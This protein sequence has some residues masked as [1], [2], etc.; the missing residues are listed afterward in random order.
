MER[1]DCTDMLTIEFTD[2]FD[3][4]VDTSEQVDNPFYV[5]MSDMVK[6]FT[7]NEHEQIM[8]TVLTTE[9]QRQKRVLIICSKTN[10]KLFE[11]INENMNQH[12][13][14]SVCKQCV[15]VKCSSNI[16]KEKQ[17]WLKHSVVGRKFL[18]KIEHPCIILYDYEIVIPMLELTYENV[19]IYAN[20]CGYIKYDYNTLVRMVSI[21]NY[22][23]QQRPIQY[24]DVTQILG[25]Y[26]WKM[27]YNEFNVSELTLR[28]ILKTSNVN[29]QMNNY[30]FNKQKGIF[31]YNIYT[32][33]KQMHYRHYY[34][35]TPTYSENNIDKNT[36]TAMITD[37]IC[38]ASK[39]NLF[40]AFAL[41]KQ[42]CHLVFN[43]GTVLKCM[44]P[45]FKKYN[46]TYCD[47]LSYA[48]LSMYIEE[49]MF[50]THA[51]VE[52]RYIFRIND[53]HELPILNHENGTLASCYNILPINETI[54]SKNPCS[55]SKCSSVAQKSGMIDNIDGF[56]KKFNLFTTRTRNG[57]IFDGID[58]KYFAITGSTMTACIPTWSF[59]IDAL[60]SY[61]DDKSYDALFLQ[62][63][64]KYYGSSDI[65]IVCSE[66]TLIGY[67]MET[68]KLFCRVK[69]NLGMAVDDERVISVPVKKARIVIDSIKLKE[70]LN[71]IIRQHP[72]IEKLETIKDI[73]NTNDTIKK[74][75]YDIYIKHKQQ[76]NGTTV[77]ASNVMHQQLFDMCQI[78]D[79]NVRVSDDNL[80]KYDTNVEI[81]KELRTSDNK[82][83]VCMI[84]SETIRYKVM[85]NPKN[86]ETDNKLIRSFE[87]FRSRDGN[88]PLSTISR[89]HLPCVRAF[90]DGSDVYMLPS[91]V[92][93]YMTHVNIEY[94]YFAG[95]CE[96][97]DIII[98]YWTRGY[99]TILN[100][101]ELKIITQRSP[102][103]G[104]GIHLLRG[105]SCI[106]KLGNTKPYNSELYQT[107]FKNV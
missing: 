71:D 12:D 32:A 66:P 22:F 10:E 3:D 59:L 86:K 82:K 46:K 21:S 101:R 40:N 1:T 105:W 68:Y 99:S 2:D 31:K 91:C 102:S 76:E 50:G 75:F 62:Y 69:Q 36:V 29:D 78:G 94:N 48:M 77:K 39:Y 95:A 38:D 79:F 96:P 16:L 49:C 60:G 92:I 13:I 42:H 23:N 45:L 100:E 44:S 81:Y 63:I 4:V 70:I 106:D 56:R 30:D 37:T 67:V 97:A 5:S 53:A 93:A 64:D 33:M 28:R 83:C 41:S 72:E 98:K 90:Y 9:K 25:D 27:R 18:E 19:I 103:I 47:V 34:V 57:N 11:C 26:F 6:R 89:F 74:H 84:I 58:W 61:T 88:N 15:I 87:V 73:V 20:T 17:H 54:L 52:N 35:S 43:N 55:V 24:R 80:G 107:L 85:N 14:D 51:T 65:D 104:M 8:K 7:K